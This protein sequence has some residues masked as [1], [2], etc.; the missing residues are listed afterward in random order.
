MRIEEV[1]EAALLLM[2]RGKKNANDGGLSKMS[3]TMFLT[4]FT[5]LIEVDAPTP[6][7]VSG[8]A[9]CRLLHSS[10]LEF[11]IIKPDVFGEE[12]ALHITSY[13]IADACLLYLT[14]PI[15]SKPLQM[16]VL[17]DGAH[18]WTDALGRSMDEH[19][20]AQYAAKNWA[21]HLE[22]VEPGS[23]LQSRVASFVGSAHFQTCVQLQTLWVQGKFDVYYVN[24][25]P[26]LLRVLPAWFIRPSAKA[27]VSKQWA[28]YRAL[29]RDWQRVLSCGGC[30]DSDP[31]CPFLEY[32]GEVDRIWWAALG[33]G[34]T[35]SSL[36]SRYTSFLLAEGSGSA[37][38]RRAERYEALSIAD[39]R[40]TVLRLRRVP[41]LICSSPF[42]THRFAAVVYGTAR[43]AP[44]NLSANGGPRKRPPRRRAS[45]QSRASAQMR[46]PATGACTQRR[47]PKGRLGSSRARRRSMTKVGCCA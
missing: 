1:R 47:P 2:T 19:H 18:T 17:P 14:R 6:G 41:L 32:R 45:N 26:S 35:F 22:D 24:G 42:T 23:A 43:P 36:Q 31:D 9:T 16:E 20:L 4:K 38:S 13:A 5:A 30:H 40:I 3:L 37:T 21:R 10:V 28:D 46:R 12:R 39:G 33:P 25:R 15:Y 29:L 11:L 27:A 44:S 8:A 34:N 7:A